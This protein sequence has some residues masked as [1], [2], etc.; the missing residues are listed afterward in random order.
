MATTKGGLRV[1]Y[2]CSLESIA[3]PNKTYVLDRVLQ[4]IGHIAPICQWFDFPIVGLEASVLI[5]ALKEKDID[6]MILLALTTFVSAFLL[7]LLQPIIAKQIL[8]WFGGSAAVWSTCLV[9]FQAM[10]LAG[11]FYSDWTLRK[12]GIRKQAWL[13]LGLIVI[14]LAL[15]PIIPDAAWKPNGTEGISEQPALRIV[16]LLA[17][18]IGLPYFLL[19]TTSPLVQAW[20][21]RAH[22][23]A[24]PYRLFALSN[25]ASMLA[26]P[27][28]PFLFEPNVSVHDQ[29]KYWS[30][31][32]AVFTALI[33]CAIWQ[34]LKIERD[35]SPLPDAKIAPTESVFAAPT[36]S[37]KFIWAALSALGSI[38]LLGVTNHLT[39]NIS[40][41]P[42]LWI[43]PLAVYL[44]TFILCFNSRDGASK[45]YPKSIALPQTAL[46][47]LAMAWLLADTRLEFML[48][49]HI[50]VF[51]GGLFIT[52]MYCHGELVARKPAPAHLTT[53]YLMIS[54]GGAVGAF[55]VG[56]VAPLLLPGYY[57][58]GFALFTLAGFAT[59]LLWKQLHWAWSIVGIAVYAFALAASIFSI[60]EYRRETIVASRNFYG[61][62]RVREFAGGETADHKRSLVHGAILHGDQYVYGPRR[63][64]ATTYYQATSGVG[65]A[66]FNRKETL[67]RPIRVGVIGLGA[68]TLAVY[69][70][71]GDVFRFYE[72]NPD[73]IDIAQR[74]FTYLKDSEATIE[75]SLGDARLSLERE[76]PQRL[77]VL[78][79]DAFS[80]DSIPVHLMTVE[81]LQVY[82]RH[83]QPDGIIAFHVSNRFLELKPVVHKI[84]ESRGFNVA[85]IEEAHDNDDSTS[86][87]WILLSKD[88]RTLRAET[89]AS[90]AKTIDAK[91]NW[92]AWTDDF[93]NLLQVLK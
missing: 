18:T 43:V 32:F 52:C 50:I 45:W 46:A 71:K 26:L 11:Y 66:I 64:F 81:A 55:L 30:I 49:L 73:V 31:G 75:L 54:I 7:F 68:G 4:F 48:F 3:D 78:A 5:N 56:I 35:A 16:L 9:F 62:L 89:I 15:L 72:I 92:K 76:T 61:T 90:I 28:Y 87:D 77:D 53:F 21:A 23:A 22:P 60:N 27:G 12:L 38:L 41:I 44:L 1:G 63:Y 36:R 14:A 83:L 42:L 69:G 24:Q 6:R 19:S 40:S 39:Q 34:T 2:T 33:G 88:P 70:K 91:S 20:F 67:A 10:L 29:A 13:H 74:D 37:E 79:V 84:A 59:W 85:W 47:I 58:L 8:P 65:V 80:S 25:L 86:T 82:E 93:N 57:E 51:T 17:A